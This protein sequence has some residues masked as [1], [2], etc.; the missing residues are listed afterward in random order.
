MPE[1][2]PT[3]PDP[4]EVAWTRAVQY[5]EKLAEALDQLEESRGLG[6]LTG[7]MKPASIAKAARTLSA[8]RAA[9]DAVLGRIERTAAKRSISGVTR[10]GDRS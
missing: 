8:A 5:A 3:G 4:A 2:E 9:L 1:I 10:P 6:R 7:R